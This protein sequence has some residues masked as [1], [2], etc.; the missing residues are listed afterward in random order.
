MSQFD[1]LLIA[2]FIGDFLFQTSWMAQ[3]KATRWLPLFTHVFIYTSIV[4]LFGWLS[5]G[6]SIEGIALIFIAHLILD[7]KKFVT[8]WVQKIQQ[9]KGPHEVWLS[10][11]ADQ[12]F[13]LIILAI[14]IQLS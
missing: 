6:L 3:Y 5:G 1:V 7:R 2:H 13:H 12:I 4:A 10:I 14:A 8:F 11:M 9:V